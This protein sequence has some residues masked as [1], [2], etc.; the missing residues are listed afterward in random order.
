M[1]V[2]VLR[3][4]GYWEALLGMGLSFDVCGEKTVSKF[5]TGGGLGAEVW[6]KKIKRAASLAGLG[7]G[8]DKFLRQIALWVYIKA[9]LYWWK[10]MD[11]YKIGTVTSSESTMHTLMSRNLTQNDFEDPIP[12]DTLEL[13]NV[14][15]ACGDFQKLNN[16]LPQSYLQ[17]R[18]WSGN[19]EN[20]LNIV[21]QRANH[22]LKQWQFL[23]NSLRCQIE[24]PELIWSVHCEKP[25]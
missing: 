3:E 18:V 13:L 11:Q 9:P 19:Y 2:T 25:C 16:E 10:Q 1:R 24:H 15:I 5:I 20:V 22:K 7:G 4:C 6:A 21:Q 23:I 12:E 14:Y 17:G 8:H